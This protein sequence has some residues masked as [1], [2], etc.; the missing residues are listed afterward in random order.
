MDLSGSM[1]GAGGVKRLLLASENSGT[2][3]LNRYHSASDGNRNASKYS[4]HLPD[5]QATSVDEEKVAME[6]HYEYDVL[7]NEIPIATTGAESAGLSY[8]FSTKYYDEETGFY[9]YGYRYYDPQTRRWP[10]RDPIEELGHELLKDEYYLF[11]DVL[12][13]D[14]VNI[15]NFAG[16][17]SINYF[18]PNGEILP[19]L[20]AGALAVWGIAEAAE[21]IQ[22]WRLAELE[23]EAVQAEIEA[24]GIPGQGECHPL[25]DAVDDWA[26]EAVKIIGLFP[27][28]TLTGPP[29]EP[30]W[31]DPRDPMDLTAAVADLVDA[32]SDIGRKSKKRS[33]ENS[34]AGFVDAVESM[35]YHATRQKSTG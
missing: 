33:F 18:D 9:Y 11:Y 17:S 19:L 5:E 16:N 30:G 3:A 7:A 28:T 29:V 25:H 31:V 20:G 2:Q 4:D 6:A 14:V 21:A 8:R 35:G 34:F 24:G 10:S 26:D 32:A 1:Q 13:K 12:F 27:G 15:Y 22:D 23:A